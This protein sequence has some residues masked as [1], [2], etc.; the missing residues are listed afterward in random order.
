MG[1][2][3][4]KIKKLYAIC[5]AVHIYVSTALFSLLIFFCITGLLLNHLSWISEEGKVSGVKQGSLPEEVSD[6]FQQNFSAV[7]AMTRIAPYLK[8]TYQLT[9]LSSFDWDKDANELILDYPIPAGYALVV[10][11]TA[12]FNYDIEYQQ[13]NLL[14]VLNDLHKGRHS[15]EV[16]SWVIDASAVLI[17]LFSFTGLFILFQNKKKRQFGLWLTLLGSITPIIIYYFFIPRLSGVL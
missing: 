11:D 8:D 15:G 16:W 14:S 3:L 10:I 9:E 5:R 6:A 7:N 2:K 17:C 12:S 1:I 13:A 4:I